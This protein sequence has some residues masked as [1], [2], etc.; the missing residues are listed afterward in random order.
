M[1]SPVSLEEITAMRD[2][3]GNELFAA[4]CGDLSGPAPFDM[5]ATAGMKITVADVE[6]KRRIVDRT[7][8]ASGSLSRRSFRQKWREVV[9][10]MV[11][12]K[13]LL[14][15]ISAGFDAHKRDPL[16]SLDLVEDDF[17]WATKL[18]MDACRCCGESMQR[19]AV[20]KSTNSTGSVEDSKIDK[21]ASEEELG[22]S[23]ETDSTTL[24]TSVD[25]VCP[26]KKFPVAIPCISILEGGYN[27]E[28]ISSSCARHV[29]VLFNEA[30]THYQDELVHD[31]NSLYVEGEDGTENYST[32]VDD[33]SLS[34]S[35]VSIE[36]LEQDSSS[37][38][39]D[40][41]V[42]C[43]GGE[44]FNSCSD[45]SGGV[46]EEDAVQGVSE[47]VETTKPKSI[48]EIL[49][50]LDISI[51]SLM[52]DALLHVQSTGVMESSDECDKDNELD[53]EEGGEDGG[54]KLSPIQDDRI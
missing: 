51:N 22:M 24:S 23:M 13:P 32:G 16:A 14:V 5:P 47:S 37:S 11:R 36:P 43:I 46:G 28:A 20:S 10:E 8:V 1:L 7:I 41:K 52:I 42:N 15:I 6:E 9:Y 54:G 19:M 34:L 29:R 18:V 44:S 50:S 12:F 26:R 25:G 2:E 53:E 31:N 35:G 33:L 27:I 17:E 4:I 3:L 49:A 40:E 38:V 39:V 21:F 30:E 45:G 48:E